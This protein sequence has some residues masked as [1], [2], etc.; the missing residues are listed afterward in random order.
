VFVPLYEELCSL[1]LPVPYQFVEHA[2]AALCR[3]GMWSDALSMLQRQVAGQRP[4]SS[5][6]FHAV[7]ADLA[8]R[9]D[10]ATADG[11]LQTM[12]ASR[13]VPLAATY[14]A[15]IRHATLER[16][17]AMLRH[18]RARGALP[19]PLPHRPGVV[20]AVG[21]PP[22][23][24]ALLVAEALDALVAAPVGGAFPLLLFIRLFLLIYLAWQ[25]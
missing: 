3:A 19:P 10:W 6:M 14:D 23:V 11:L 24:A 18:A 9:Q 12:A 7:L 22:Y 13:C 15:M 8:V 16:A 20:C 25:K 17:R 4:V 2:T 21:L 5:S 1:Q